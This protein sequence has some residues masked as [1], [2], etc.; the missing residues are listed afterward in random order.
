MSSEPGPRVAGMRAS[1]NVAGRRR[2]DVL[3]LFD[4]TE[5][6]GMS[7]GAGAPLG[8]RPAK[9]AGRRRHGVEVFSGLTEASP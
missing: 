1:A 7:R 9:A 8:M 5:A 3:V 2:H 6:A 4:L